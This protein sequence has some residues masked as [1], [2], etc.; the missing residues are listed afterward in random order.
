LSFL[1]A[2]K[3]KNQ[4]K[5]TTTLLLHHLLLLPPRKNSLGPPSLTLWKKISV[6]GFDQRA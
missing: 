2:S 4:L 3:K 6:W 1:R 5:K